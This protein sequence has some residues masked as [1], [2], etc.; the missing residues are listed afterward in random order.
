MS[1]KEPFTNQLRGSAVAA[2]TPAWVGMADF[3]TR[4]ISPS[5]D[6]SEEEIQQLL[7]ENDQLKQRLENMEEVLQQEIN[8]QAQM[9][10]SLQLYE[11][12]MEADS[13]SQ[14][15]YKELQGLIQ[16]Q[17]QSL[18]AQVIFRGASSWNSS[19]WINVG[20]DQ[21]DRLGRVVVAKNSPVTLGLSLI[22]VVDYVGSRQSRVRLITDSGLVPS[23]RA[24]RGYVQNVH[25]EHHVDAL[26]ASLNVRED[27]FANQRDNRILI[28]NLQILKQNLEEGSGGWMLAKGELR[29]SSQPFWRSGGQLLRG[30]GF[31]YDYPDEEG[32][33]RDLRAANQATSSLKAGL[34]VPLLK[35]NDLLVTTGMDGVFPPGLHV[36]EVLKIDL[37]KE[38]SYA[39]D[40]VAKPTAGNLDDLKVV[41]VLPPVTSLP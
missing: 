17:T 37:L 19:L 8:V 4:L 7:F 23:V 40:L 3:K 12:G 10:R 1:L 36:A 28:Q 41:F 20:S 16:Y 27:L 18:P 38:G 6:L 26:I 25:L 22:G 24:A 39:Y 2:F 29:G 33:A 34:Q 32:A 13:F 30:V 15:R 5:L 31:N 9:V 21:N 35:V 11:K 14:R